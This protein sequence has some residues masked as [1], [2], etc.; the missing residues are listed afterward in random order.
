VPGLC[1]AWT[2]GSD[3]RTW[4]FTCRDA[5]AIAAELRRVGRLP[6]SPSRWLFAGARVS[7]PTARTLVVRLPFAWRRFPYALTAAAAAPRGVPGPFRLV[8]GSAD[9]V[10]AERAG[11]RVVFR[12]LSSA[13]AVR[14]FRSG[15]I[16]EAPVPTG[17]ADLLRERFDVRARELLALDTI[18]FQRH[19][20]P[21]LRRAYRDTANRGDYRQLLDTSLA[22]GVVPSA[23]R[24]DPAAFRRA[25]KAIPDLPRVAVRI[26]RPPALEYGADVLYGQWREA[27]LGPLLVRPGA[28]SAARFER[29][30]A[31]YPQAEA[32]PAALV[33][34]DRLGDRAEL[35]RA[36]ARVNQKSE[37]AA[38]DRD[39]TGTAEAIPIAWVTDERL[40]S[41]RL[42]GWSE[43][44]LGT[45]DYGRVATR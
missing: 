17:D 25:L 23:E 32:L 10:V 37:L 21:R 22:V 6:A 44:L 11:K 9:E 38:V 1:S 36:V 20:D 4:R 43:D 31:A 29:L 24:P 3:F 27:G 40:V 18:V 30:T 5:R 19:L 12:R 45:V 26:A 14:A 7:A 13:E 41:R 35:L 28:R 15:R 39:L 16:D 2:S 34:A 42:Q 33:L 8:R